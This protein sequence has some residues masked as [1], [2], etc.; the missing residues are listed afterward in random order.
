M[1]SGRLRV[2]KRYYNYSNPQFSVIVHALSNAV[3]T[4][5][6]DILYFEDADQ[7]VR[8]SRMVKADVGDNEHVFKNAVLKFKR[9]NLT[10]PCTIYNFSELELNVDRVN[11]NAM[12]GMYQSTHFGCFIRSYPMIYEVVLMSMFSDMADF[13]KGMAIL[14]SAFRY[15]LRVK[16]PFILNGKDA[17][18]VIRLV[19]EDLVPGGFKV[20]MA[21]R[22][23]KGN[24]FDV[25]HSIR[26][27][28]NQI[29]CSGEGI[30]PVETF[31]INFRNL[32][33]DIYKTLQIPL[34]VSS[35]VPTGST[36]VELDTPIVIT[37]GAPL[38]SDSVETHTKIS[39]KTDVNFSW[40]AEFTELTI[41]PLTDWEPDTQYTIEVFGNSV[42]SYKIQKAQIV[43]N[44]ILI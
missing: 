3:R 10:F 5:I 44:T 38:N 37:Y 14:N 43:F 4:L 13:Q 42:Q 22:E 12:S 23:E 25:D 17:N 21:D 7:T 30:F 11:S 34:F 8:E 16:V 32:N 20:S 29:E 31:E 15:P 36:E 39:P 41:T 27:Y 40:N 19:R 2:N 35:S 6:S 24:I 28:Y 18:M 1:L 9:S 26:V 33:Q